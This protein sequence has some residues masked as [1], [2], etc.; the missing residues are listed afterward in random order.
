M[1]IRTKAEGHLQ[2]RMIDFRN[3]P[4]GSTEGAMSS[5][6][7]N[8]FLTKFVD[9]GRARFRE[10]DVWLWIIENRKSEQVYD[11]VRKLQPDMMY[12][13]RTTSLQRRKA[14]TQR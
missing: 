13:S 1:V 2:F 8:L 6:F 5:L 4:Y 7:Y 9:Y 12:Q 3:I 11:L 10:V 14:H